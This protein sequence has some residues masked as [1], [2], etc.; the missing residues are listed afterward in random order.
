MD[1]SLIATSCKDKKIRVID[2]RKNE[3]VTVSEYY[4][5]VSARH[6]M[7]NSLECPLY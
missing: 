1:G 2:P 3:V 4:I 5:I 7:F 6:D